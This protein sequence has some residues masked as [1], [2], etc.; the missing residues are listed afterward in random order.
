MIAEI[1]REIIDYNANNSA[2]WSVKISIKTAFRILQERIYIYIWNWS[3]ITF[4]DLARLFLGFISI[5]KFTICRNYISSGI[6]LKIIKLDQPSG[7]SNHGLWIN[8]RKT[9]VDTFWFAFERL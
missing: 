4:S 9:S 2:V 5:N 1:F 3:K 6:F 8:E 7:I